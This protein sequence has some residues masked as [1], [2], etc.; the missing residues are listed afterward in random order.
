M[1]RS[2]FEA[3]SDP[4]KGIIMVCLCAYMLLSMSNT[5]KFCFVR[6]KMADI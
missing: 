2:V 1:H 3:L 4:V 5:V 6:V